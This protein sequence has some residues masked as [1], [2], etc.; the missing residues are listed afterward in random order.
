MSIETHDHFRVIEKRINEVMLTRAEHL[1]KF[2]A[3]FFKQVGSH[4]ASQYSLV[5][6]HEKS[7]DAFKFTWHFER[8][9]TPTASQGSKKDD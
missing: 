2:C 6:M 4:E 7:G 5:E 9:P 1:E 3:A 8:R